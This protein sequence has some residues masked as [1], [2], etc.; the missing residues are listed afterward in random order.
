MLLT[1][2]QFYMTILLLFMILHILD[3]HLWNVSNNCHLHNLTNYPS[4][5]KWLL[6]KSGL[7]IFDRLRD[8][9]LE[10]HHWKGVFIEKKIW[11]WG[12]KTRAAAQAPLRN[13][14]PWEAAMLTVERWSSKFSEAFITPLN[15]ATSLLLFKSM[16]SDF[17]LGKSTAGQSP[18]VLPHVPRT[19]PKTWISGRGSKSKGLKRVTMPGEN[20]CAPDP[21]N[22]FRNLCIA[23]RCW[24]RL[25]QKEEIFQIGLSPYVPEADEML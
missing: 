25:M 1:I 15:P 10:K 7:L 14:T 9:D 19:K 13:P 22:C 20:R 5:V 17:K 21:E 18:D 6:W 24:K 23:P 11:V 2:L 4:V 16:V 3:L 8:V 12:V